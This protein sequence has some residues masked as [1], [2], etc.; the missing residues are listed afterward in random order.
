MDRKGD[1]HRLRNLVE[2]GDCVGEQVPVHEGRPVE[3]HD[4]VAATREPVSGRCVE[5]TD[6]GTHGD[7]RVDHGVPN[8]VDPGIV[9]ALAQKVV[10]C[11]R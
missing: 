7:E 10:S 8:G 2:S 11:L 1:R 5:G 3:R 9:D 4:E 6:P